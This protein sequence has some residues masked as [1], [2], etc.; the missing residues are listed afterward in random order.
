MRSYAVQLGQH[1]GAARFRESL[2]RSCISACDYSIRIWL[3]IGK[4]SLASSLFAWGCFSIFFPGSL[5]VCSLP[6]GGLARGPLLRRHRARAGEREGLRQQFVGA[7]AR[8]VVEHHRG[9]HHL[10]GLGRVDQ[11]HDAVVHLFG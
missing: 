2:A 4:C 3:T 11:R 1:E 8:R 10:V 5:R 6:L 9:D 7:F